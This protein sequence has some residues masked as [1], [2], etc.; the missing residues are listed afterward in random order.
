MS[1][2]IVNTMTVLKTDP[3]TGLDFLFLDPS[4]GDEQFHPTQ[5]PVPVVCFHGSGATGHAHDW[6]SVVHKASNYAP[7]LFYERKS[8]DTNPK[9]T[10]VDAVEDLIQLLQSLRVEPPYILV[11]HSFGGTIAREFLHHHPTDVAGM[12]LAETGQETPTKHDASQYR[13]QALGAKP[14]SVIH[15][16]TVGAR[17]AEGSTD[18]M[19]KLRELWAAE[20]E[21][22]KKAQLQLS[23]QARYVRLNDC[24][25][26]VVRDRP[27]V[28][29]E[30]ICWVLQH[31]EN[32]SRARKENFTIW[33][34][35]RHW[36]WKF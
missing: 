24:G 32:H 30:E 17:L 5:A 8:S 21:R 16:N 27:D 25:H 11:A 31:L 28:V 20:D 23:S 12:L 35:W 2:K 18:E 13:N 9:Y 36:W 1:Q 15:A 19:K 3:N 22:L 14:L 33:R 34:A 7:I 4:Q 26:H 29:V 6:S 10:T